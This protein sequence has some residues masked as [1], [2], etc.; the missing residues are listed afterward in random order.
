MTTLNEELTESEK[1]MFRGLGWDYLFNTSVTAPGLYRMAV[2]KAFS[3]GDK[4]KFVEALRAANFR[5]YTG[6]YRGNYEHDGVIIDS[7][8]NYV[9]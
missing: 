9:P 5:L 6:K 2:D 7:L 1:V 3:Y 8:T 4:G